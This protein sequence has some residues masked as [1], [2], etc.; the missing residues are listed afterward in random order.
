MV[1]Y[2]YDVMRPATTSSLRIS[3]VLILVGI[4]VPTCSG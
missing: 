1:C 4:G 2:D 3:L